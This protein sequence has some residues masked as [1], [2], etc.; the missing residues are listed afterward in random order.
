[1][2]ISFPESLAAPRKN[3]PMVFSP[4]SYTTPKFRSLTMN[5]LGSLAL[6]IAGFILGDHCCQWWFCRTKW[7]NLLCHLSHARLSYE[8]RHWRSLLVYF[9]TEHA[10]GNRARMRRRWSGWF[11]IC[12]RWN[13]PVLQYLH[14]C[15][16]SYV[17][18]Q[19]FL[20]RLLCFSLQRGI[21]RDTDG[22]LTKRNSWPISK[23]T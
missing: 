16:S 12:M 18:L 6:W 2:N 13:V 11:G 4:L 22:D 9:S 23:H 21:V 20:V 1:M 15:R 10:A 19:Y 3:F 7:W 5:H 14:P 8:G 17:V